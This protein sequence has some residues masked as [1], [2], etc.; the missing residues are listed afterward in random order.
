MPFFKKKSLLISFNPITKKP[1]LSKILITL[2]K[3]VLS[4]LL[5][6]KTLKILKNDHKSGFKSIKLG[7]F[8][9]PRKIIFLIEFSL[10]I[11]IA[12]FPLPIGNE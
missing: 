2:L 8:N 9:P 6:N 10:K 3:T 11:L 5:K 4:V 1:S 7:F 12:S